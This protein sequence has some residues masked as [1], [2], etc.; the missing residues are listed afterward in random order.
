MSE[1]HPG[2][3]DVE[4][5]LASLAQFGFPHDEMVTFLSEHEG[6]T[7]ERLN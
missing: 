6:G 1:A 5:R 4:A 7:Q 3:D 2:S